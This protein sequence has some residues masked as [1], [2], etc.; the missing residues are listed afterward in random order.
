MQFISLGSGSR[1][2]ATLVSS[3]QT[4]LMIDC[5]FS[6][7]E[8]CRRL[9]LAEI[10]P[11]SLDAILVTHEHGDH[12]RGIARLARRFGLTVW[13]SRGTAAYFRDDNIDVE[14]INVHTPFQIGDIQIVPVPV[15]HDANEPCQFV[16]HAGNRC[17]GLLTDVGSI[18]PH[19]IQAYAACDAMLLEFNHDS[20]MLADSDYPAS[21]KR[22]IAGDLGH[23]NNVQSSELLQQLL[24]GALR[25]VVAGHLSES[26]N[27]RDKV[28]SWLQ[29]VVDGHDCR[30]DVASQ[31]KAVG[32]YVLDEVC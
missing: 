4:M 13:S 19:I 25:F 24:P 23:L 18:T 10:Q 3:G 16:F 29:S 15:P 20:A 6:V 31:D 14:L 1:G 8:V 5:G 12:I 22:R 7:K 2:N 28:R 17:F 30:F 11:Q 27:S 26:N 9:Q 21:V 32:W